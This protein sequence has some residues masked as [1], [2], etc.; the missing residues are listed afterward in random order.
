MYLL[1][2]DANDLNIFNVYIKNDFIVLVH[3]NT[4]FKFIA[5]DTAIQFQGL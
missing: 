1:H 2:H 4:V 5:V 3:I